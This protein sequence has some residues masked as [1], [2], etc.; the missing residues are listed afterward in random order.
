VKF[1]VEGVGNSERNRCSSRGDSPGALYASSAREEEKTH[2]I[3]K[4]R[5]S[6]SA[7][8]A[9]EL[10]KSFPSDGI[11]SLANFYSAKEWLIVR[12]W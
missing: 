11:L 12:S 4:A 1:H 2:P 9:K 6:A 7:F 10:K 8:L 3:T 5:Q